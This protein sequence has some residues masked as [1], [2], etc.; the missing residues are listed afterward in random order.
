MACES[1]QTTVVCFHANQLI[2]KDN[3]TIPNEKATF[4]C[5]AKNL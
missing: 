5:L 3:E 4:N 1:K 2:L